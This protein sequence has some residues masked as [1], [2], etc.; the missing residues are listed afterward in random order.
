[1]Q[2]AAGKV[3]IAACPHVSEEVKQI[4]GEASA[5]TIKG[6]VIGEGDNALRIGEETVLFRH[7]K[8]FV[9][10]QDLRS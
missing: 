9:N 6:V 3:E 5:P 4:L 7:D 2:L 10:P 1:M 8:T